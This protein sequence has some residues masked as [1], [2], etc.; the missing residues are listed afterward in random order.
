MKVLVI[1]FDQRPRYKTLIQYLEDNEILYDFLQ[2]SNSGL[3]SSIKKIKQIHRKTQ[4]THTILMG[5]D[6]AAIAWAFRCY[7]MKQKQPI[8]RLGGDPI[9][10][11]VSRLRH[12]KQ[13]V[14]SWIKQT[15]RISALKIA[16]KLPK[17]FITVSQFLA[18]SRSLVNKNCFVLPVFPQT[19]RSKPRKHSQNDTVNVLT[20]TN[21]NYHEKYQGILHILK[22][23]VSASQKY[24]IKLSIIGGGDYL[25]Q[26]KSEI[27]K[28]QSENLSITA[29][30]HIDNVEHYYNNAEIFAYHSTLDSWPNVLME[31]MANGLP[32]AANNNPQFSEVFSK[33]QQAFLCTSS[34][35]S[36]FTNTLIDFIKHPEIYE[37][38]SKLSIS[39]VAEL[40]TNKNSISTFKRW[41][42]TTHHKQ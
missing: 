6:K 38:Y 23:T 9:E 3:I 8:I 28:Y 21:L 12:S 20:V 37:N 40:R 1:A 30:G 41:L 4:A 17:H 15:L 35:E 19:N 10:V 32:I 31:A 14:M 29:S 13:S 33:E 26:L 5:F 11:P 2:L 42:E 36:C 22:A 27:E 39:R 7:L 24:P 16:I 34:D 25:P 18:N